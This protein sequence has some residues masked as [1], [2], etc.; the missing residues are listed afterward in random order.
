MRRTK[1]V[2]LIIFL[3]LLFTGLASAQP[4]TSY[5]TISNQT[6]CP[7]EPVSYPFYLKNNNVFTETYRLVVE[8]ELAA[9]AKATVPSQFRLEP[10][11]ET[12]FSLIIQA[13]CG[14][15]GTKKFNAV[16][17][18]EQQKI[19]ATFPL[20]YAIKRCYNYSIATGE[21]VLQLPAFY[22]PQSFSEQQNY[23][24][25]ENE[26][27]I[28][29]LRIE[30][31]AGFSNSYQISISSTAKNLAAL[32][33]RRA[34]LN[35]SQAAVIPLLVTIPQYSQ[36]E[37][38][39]T[40]SLVS[41]LGK[42]Q[43][44]K[45]IAIQPVYCVTPVITFLGNDSLTVNYT[46]TTFSVFVSNRGTLRGTY[47]VRVTGADWIKPST[48][49]FGLEPGQG[50]ELQLVSEPE[51]N[52]AAKK[53]ELQIEITAQSSGN[54]YAKPFTVTLNGT[55]FLAKVAKAL[56]KPLSILLKYIWIIIGSLVALALIIF[57]AQ[58]YR[59]YRRLELQQPRVARRISRT[60]KVAKVAG[61]TGLTK[62]PKITLTIPIVSPFLVFLALIVAVV[63]G[64][65][66]ILYLGL[67]P[68]EAALNQ[69][70]PFTVPLQ[71]L[72]FSL[73]AN[74][75]VSIPSYNF[76]AITTDNEFLPLLLY[77]LA[78]LLAAIAIYIWMRRQ[79]KHELK[80]RKEEKKEI[81]QRLEALEALKPEAPEELKE[82][83][84]GRYGLSKVLIIG[85][86]AIV[87]LLLLAL[88]VFKFP[89]AITTFVPNRSI[90]EYKEPVID[91][92][93]PAFFIE[94]DEELEINLS[95]YFYD[96]DNDP[97]YFNA[98]IGGNMTVVIKNT[99]AVLKP[100]KGFYGASYVVFTAN[101]RKG[102]M[103]ETGA[104][105]IVVRRSQKPGILDEAIDFISLYRY[106]FIL[107]LI[108]MA[109]L[110]AVLYYR[111]RGKKE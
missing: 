73:P 52:T 99:T 74:F 110:I 102:G 27:R 89:G 3:L 29:P 32:L 64:V 80:K 14:L 33:I 81:G 76:T 78:V 34:T 57:L 47:T 104:I 103:T 100:R 106:F 55:P 13:P 4:F 8:G 10:G 105:P 60:V 42:V 44:Q 19:S 96:P 59:E 41:E 36:A 2:L 92:T 1:S 39:I 22:T 50:I 108:L 17:K 56:E 70:K 30:N 53:Y 82:E 87:L 58:Q 84:P 61:P 15:Y 48:A 20:A 97:L 93:K 16:I 75:T 71:G 25:C 66:G 85:G 46:K 67:L 62:Q 54:T 109:L 37:S 63:L 95:A 28:I 68:E 79:K 83:R 43:K 51:Q 65:A 49:S 88:A 90:E 111:E 101:D 26:S 11:Q 9:Y 24:I 31:E 77:I 18:A 12:Q 5:G 69:T 94:Q 91:A 38:N 40:L 7:C 6:S 23:A 72:N 21:A 107:G 45:T 98:T 35:A 86:I